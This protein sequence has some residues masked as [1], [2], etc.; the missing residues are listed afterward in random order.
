[1]IDQLASG[2]YPPG[3]PLPR[4][5][6]LAERFEVSR[7]VVR[8]CLR[9]LEE[10]DLIKVKHGRG[11]TV[12]PES[13]W[14]VLDPDVLRALLASQ[15][16]GDVLREYVEC[17]RGL[18]VEAAGLAAVR[19]TDDHIAR[20]RE[21]LDEMT[22]AAK[23]VREAEAGGAGGLPDAEEQFHRADI[24]FHQAVA[25]AAGNRA[26]AHMLRP[27]DQ[28]LLIARLPLA[29]PQARERRGIPEHQ[30]ILNAIAA[31]DAAAAG[32]AMGA[33]LKTVEG[34]LDEY[35]AGRRTVLR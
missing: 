17:R 21:A 35:L 7:G 29:R 24:R 8:E 3:S 11:A 34:Y 9:A 5:V 6:D 25:D 33:H 18:E 12:Q 2:V 1:M 20:L 26:L 13:A 30:R 4:E 15:A 23:G 16:G 22:Q 31:G 27:L 19:A 14:N 28:A 32:R 10:R